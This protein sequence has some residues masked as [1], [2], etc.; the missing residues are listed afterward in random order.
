[1]R[2]EI[3]D[4]ILLL[5]LVPI[6]GVFLSFFI[7][8]FTEKVKIGKRKYKYFWMKMILIVYFAIPIIMLVTFIENKKVEY[9][10][11]G[12]DFDYMRGYKNSVLYYE[13]LERKEFWILEVFFLVWVVG[14]F[15]LVIKDLYG[16][17]ELIK[18][19]QIKFRRIL[20]ENDT[21]KFKIGISSN[22][23]EVMV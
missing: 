4:L 15:V 14:I 18:G 9:I 10:W 22:G 16:I 23:I 5:Y 12:G 21:N 2:K 17:L 7:T 11:I 3:S 8:I 19:A 13:Y 6:V 1:M 20:S